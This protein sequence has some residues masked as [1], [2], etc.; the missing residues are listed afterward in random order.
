MV[1]TGF[2]AGKVVGNLRFRAERVEQ[3]INDTFLSTHRMNPSLRH[4]M[5][6][7]ACLSACLCVSANVC[8]VYVCMYVYVQMEHGARWGRRLARNGTTRNACP[9][10][11]RLRH[12]ITLLLW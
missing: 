11:V 3:E 5:H 12:M 7:P 6:K 2:R 1:T 4:C 8:S 9:S 10:I